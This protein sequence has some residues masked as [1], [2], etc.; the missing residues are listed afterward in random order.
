MTLTWDVL[1]GQM[2]K[3]QEEKQLVVD[4][5]AKLEK[6][7]ERRDTEN[8]KL[9]DEVSF[10]REQLEKAGGGDFLSKVL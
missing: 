3:L 2:A 9:K 5:V 7:L 6:E 4:R 8:R 10:L 1:C